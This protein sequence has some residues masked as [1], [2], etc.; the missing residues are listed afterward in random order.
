MKKILGLCCTICWGQLVA[1]TA[2]TLKVLESDSLHP[3]EHLIISEGWIGMTDRKSSLDIVHVGQVDWRANRALNFAQ[4]LSYLPGVSAQSTGVGIARPVIRGMSGQR[5]VVV[6]R[7]IKQEGQQ[8]G[9]DHGLEMDM[10]TIEGVEVIKGAAGLMYGGDAIGGAIRILAPK[11]STGKQ[12]LRLALQGS[13]NNQERGVF[14][15]F[16]KKWKGTKSGSISRVMISSSNKKS[17]D[18]R[19]P[20]NAF[21]YLNRTLPLKD[22]VL[23][24]T[25]TN[26]QALLGLWEMVNGQRALQHLLF[27]YRWFNQNSG[28]FPGFVGIPT[29][30]SVASDGNAGNIGW[31][32]A[33]VEHHKWM[34]QATWKLGSGMH[35]L[36][37]AIQDNKRQEMSVPHQGAFVLETASSAALMLRLRDIQLRYAWKNLQLGRANGEWGASAQQQRNTRDG[38]E[39][40]IPN[41]E[42]VTVG[43]WSL[44]S[45]PTKQN[46]GQWN[47]GLR[48]D[49]FHYQ[50]PGFVRTIQLNNVDFLWAP[51]LPT[52]KAFQGLSGS[53]GRSISTSNQWHWKWHVGRTFRVPQASELFIN[54]VHHG[55]YRHEMGDA[56]LEAEKGWQWDGMAIRTSED[57]VLK[58]SPFLQYYSS[59]IYLSPQAEFSILPDGGQVYAYVQH[60]VLMGGGECS[61]DMHLLPQL[62]TDCSVEYIANYNVSTTL[63]LPFTPP[64]QVKWG[65]TYQGKWSEN[66]EWNCQFQVRYVAAQNRVDRNEKITQD[67]ALLHG[68]VSVE[69]QS[70]NEKW[71]CLWSL[72]AR[73]LTNTRYLNNLSNYRALQLPE[74]GRWVQIGME[75]RWNDS[76]QRKIN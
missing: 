45:G 42:K 58:C 50:T 51:V 75:I 31:P 39:F 24:N 72:N 20:A 15:S 35:E 73:N 44:W 9:S 33:H 62:H 5:I 16:Q 56:K 29:L 47:G 71:S 26:E 2:D 11:W 46:K 66:W 74:Q 43:A 59:Y 54:G 63:P 21:T 32:M 30:A 68:G 18:Y 48:W 28:L 34:G 38:F 40:L 36:E 37:G 41:F 64:F 1:Q 4:T 69:Y 8:W 7:N 65:S 27:Q 52:N 3:L 22:G 76:N 49:Y 60:P 67:Y 53:L 10:F 55:T 61:M 19:L 14:A 57:W 70:P 23:N 25:A 12:E 17:S 13:N 6:E